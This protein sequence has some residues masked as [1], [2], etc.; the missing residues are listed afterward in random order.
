MIAV[1]PPRRPAPMPPPPSPSRSDPLQASPHTRFEDV[2]AVLTGSLF[3]ALALVMFH[4]SRLVPGGT[5]GIAL[6]VSYVSGWPPG[7]AVFVINLPFYL[8]AYRALGR[9]FTI[10]TFCAVGMLSLYTELLPSL[11]SFQKLDPVFSAIMGGL[12]AGTGILILIR[13]GASLGGLGVLA[14][15]LQQRKGW[16]AGVVQMAGD[17]AIVALSLVVVSLQQVALSILAAVAVNLVIAINHRPGRYFG[18]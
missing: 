4:D 8:F 17:C 13:H 1:D 5:T 9:V 16:R 14:I 10:K 6:L 15:Y 2:Q 18:I 11:V 12:L 7:P 3:V